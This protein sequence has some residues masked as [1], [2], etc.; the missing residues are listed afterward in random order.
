MASEHD[1]ELAARI[2]DGSADGVL[3]A[4]DPA[5]VLEAV[6][7][8]EGAVAVD[9]AE[10]PAAIAAARVR[11]AEVLVARARRAERA[12]L[13]DVAAPAPPTSS[14]GSAPGSAH[15]E[16][17][18]SVRFSLAILLPALAG[19]IAVYV[20]DGLV[21]AVAAPAVALVV[22][23]VVVLAHRR[24]TADAQAEHADR[25]APAATTDGVADGPAVRAAEAH[26]RR[27][28]A[29]WKLL[30][31]ELEEQVPDLASWS[32]ALRATVPITLVTVD[33]SGGEGDGACAPTTVTAPAAVRVV[34][35]QPRCREG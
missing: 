13:A 35:L 14:G 20:I 3:V 30:W 24:P 9:G 33:G 10:L 22:L 15:E 31:W 21:V 12:L 2:A 1:R 23:G 17:R 8:V 18:R 19:G 26:L 7:P 6:A 27:Q 28:Q 4:D 16:D 5:A 11:L 29:A 34:V 25:D 32:P